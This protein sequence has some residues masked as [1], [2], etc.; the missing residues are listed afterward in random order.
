MTYTPSET[1]MVGLADS[2]RILRVV[3]PNYQ[4]LQPCHATPSLEPNRP[5]RCEVRRS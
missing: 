4:D 3:F 1:G 5:I 2:A